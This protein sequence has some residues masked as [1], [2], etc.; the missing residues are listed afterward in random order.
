MS[1]TKHY[2]SVWRAVVGC[3]VYGLLAGCVTSPVQAM[4]DARQAV[5][6]AE[7]AGGEQRLPEQMQAVRAALSAAEVAL[8]SKQFK[9]ARIS[10]ERVREQAIAI[11]QLISVLP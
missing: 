2:Q 10:A 8:H 9:L 11:Q 7:Q 4:S 1:L 6:A 5:A 3:L